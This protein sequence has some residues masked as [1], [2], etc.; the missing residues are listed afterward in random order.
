MPTTPAAPCLERPAH[1]LDVG[2]AGHDEDA[3]AGCDEGRHQVATVADHAAEVEVEQHQ[4]GRS[5]DDLADEGLAVA[6]VG[7]GALDALE[8][9]RQ[10]QGLGE[11]LVVVD[12]DGAGQ[13]AVGRAVGGQGAAWSCDRH[14]VVRRAQGGGLAGRDAA[15][16]G[17]VPGGDPGRAA[18]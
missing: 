14:L 15:P 1:L 9:E 10:R 17:S 13:G 7:H 2:R 5:V 11:Q 4:R 6:E 12:Q 18:A 8:P 16:G 3:A